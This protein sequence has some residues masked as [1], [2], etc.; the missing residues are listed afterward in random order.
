MPDYA[1]CPQ[2]SSTRAA[3]IRWTWWGGLLGPKLFTHVKCTGCGAKYNGKTGKSN[4]GGILI[5]LIVGT[6]IA[7]LLGLVLFALR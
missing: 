5:F 1:P 2:C 7:L 4:V 3:P 6:V